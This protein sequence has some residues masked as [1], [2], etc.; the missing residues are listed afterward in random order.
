MRKLRVRAF[1]TFILLDA[2]GREIERWAG[3][4]KS[5]GF[6]QAL[7]T[8]AADPRPLTEKIAAFDTAPSAPLALRIAESLAYQN[9][10]LDA[11][12][13]Y[14]RAAALDPAL[15]KQVAPEIFFQTYSAVSEGLLP[16]YPLLVAGQRAI[17]LDPGNAWTARNVAS[18]LA[19][20]WPDDLDRALLKPY[21]DFALATFGKKS[22]NAWEEE[23]KQRLEQAL[24]PPRTLEQRIAEFEK[25]PTADAAL[26]LGN[27]LLAEERYSEAIPLYQRAGTLEQKHGDSES[28]EAFASTVSRNALA[29]AAQGARAGTVPVETLKQAYERYLALHPDDAD[30]ANVAALYLAVG[31]SKGQDNA[32]LQPRLDAAIAAFEK[33]E[34]AEKKQSLEQLQIVR[35]RAIENDPA[36]AIA[37]KQKTFGEGWQDDPSELSEFARFLVRN[38]LDLDEAERV[39]RRAVELSE[40][41]RERSRAAET[42]AR[43]LEKRGERDEAIAALET[44]LQGAPY[45]KGLKRRLAELNASAGDSHP[46]A[47]S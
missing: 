23:E 3:F 34:D 33:S 25:A 15:E 22:K 38:D 1:P 31:L 18:M 11:L 19:E 46:A 44:A 35:A 28:H 43:V 36:K 16:F 26:S 17:A 6:I 4:G 14:Q 40:P 7:D 41:G 13:F 29:A 10:P 39:A 20:T 37:L 27:E 24:G 32:F 12:S 21:V 45:D 9:R 30:V 2:S 42:L 5:K 8:A 47:S